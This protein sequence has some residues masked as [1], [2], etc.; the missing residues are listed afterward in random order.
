MNI[1]NI[2]LFV[3]SRNKIKMYAS[4]LFSVVFNFS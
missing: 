1:S 3:S 2:D 4:K